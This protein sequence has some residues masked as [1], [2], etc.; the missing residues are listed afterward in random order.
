MFPPRSLSPRIGA[1]STCRWSAR[2]RRRLLCPPL[3]PPPACRAA[4]GAFARRHRAHSPRSPQPRPPCRARV[5]RWPL[6]RRC[7]PRSPHAVTRSPLCAPPPPPPLLRCSPPLPATA[8]HRPLHATR[9]G[10]WAHRQTTCFGCHS[11]QLATHWQGWPAPALF[12]RGSCC[13]AS[14]RRCSFRCRRMRLRRCG[15]RWQP[16]WGVTRSRAADGKRRAWAPAPRLAPRWASLPRIM[17]P[18]RGAWWVRRASRL[19]LL[20][21]RRRVSSPGR[22]RVRCRSRWASCSAAA[23][24]RPRRRPVR[25]R[26]RSLCSGQQ[27]PRQRA[28]AQRLCSRHRA[29]HRRRSEAARGEPHHRRQRASLGR[30][31][32]GPCCSQVCCS[33]AAWAA[34][35]RQTP[36]RSRPL[37]P[38]PRCAE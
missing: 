27:P 22:A 13:C 9:C 35:R 20:L 38:P 28:P 16:H 2:S 3:L 25:K 17:T 19:Q 10:S 31:A 15:A 32:R 7:P 4:C 29:L 5:A 12:R 33:G 21:L 1:A 8:R 24:S 36:R 18:R 6:K 37:Q 34:R 26:L 11:W 14:W 23:R 30:H